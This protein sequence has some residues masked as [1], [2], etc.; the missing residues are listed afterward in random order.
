MI[1]LILLCIAIICISAP[2]WP[3][4]ANLA[5]FALSLIALLMLVTHWHSAL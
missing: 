4:P 5:A 3:H 1:P 2:G